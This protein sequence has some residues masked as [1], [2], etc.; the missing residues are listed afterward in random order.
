MART[1]RGW[2]GKSLHRDA[3]FSALCGI[4]EQIAE[5]DGCADTTPPH[6]GG[7]ASGGVGAERRDALGASQR[8]GRAPSSARPRLGLRRVRTSRCAV[9]GARSIVVGGPAQ[10]RR[11]LLRRWPRRARGASS[12]STGCPPRAAADGL[13]E[14]P[15]CVTRL[16][17]HEIR[18][19]CV[20]RRDGTPWGSPASSREPPQACSR[21]S[22]VVMS[23]RVSEFMLSRQ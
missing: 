10:G 6:G 12:G 1:G 9:V 8:W 11:R 4:S 13:V 15:S 21:G 7:L 19:S 18:A 23:M 22:E 3:R 17:A 20:R 2:R 5:P 14:R 16:A